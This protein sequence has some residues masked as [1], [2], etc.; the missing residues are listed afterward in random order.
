MNLAALRLVLH[1]DVS[2]PVSLR[3]CTAGDVL[4]HLYAVVSSRRHCV[5]KVLPKR[6]SAG[7]VRP[8]SCL[9][10]GRKLDLKKSSGDCQA[11]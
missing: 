9:A 1:I 7:I 8:S 2:A 4:M 10:V 3:H 6:S 5:G 11:A